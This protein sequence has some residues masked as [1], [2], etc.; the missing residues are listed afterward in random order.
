MPD[1]LLTRADLREDPVGGPVEV[2]GQRLAG[3]HRTGLFMGS[4]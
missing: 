3:G 1:H 4:F 2:D